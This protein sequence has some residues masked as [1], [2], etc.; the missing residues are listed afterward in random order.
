M[1]STVEKNDLNDKTR[2]TAA[3]LRDGVRRVKDDVRAAA[4]TV[5]SDIEDIA[6]QTGR[7]ARDLYGT[8]EENV[9]GVVDAMS[10]KI[11]DNPV[12]SSL[13]GLAVGVFFGVLLARR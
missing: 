2:E 13:I 6:R 7:Q 3:D 5:K 8:A 9:S 11:Y 4:G 12:Q 1:Y 10:A